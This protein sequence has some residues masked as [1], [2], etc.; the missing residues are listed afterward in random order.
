M[1][2]KTLRAGA[3]TRA[4]QYDM[5]VPQ[6]FETLPED[7]DYSEIFDP[8]FWRHHTAVKPGSLVRLRHALGNFDVIVNV[9]HKVAGGVLVEFFSGRPPRGIDPYKV[10]DDTR[11][12]ALK[13]R[14]APIAEDG[15]PVVR[16][17]YLAKTKFR[18][19][20]LGGAEVARD[21]STSAEAETVLLNYLNGLNMRNP[22]NDEL[23]EHAK[24]KQAA[25]AAAEKK[26]SAPAGA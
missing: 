23:L 16:T 15:K 14:V 5:T 7:V 10:Q 25:L 11:A 3:L 1:T 9:V 4:S 8:N 18:V 24:A 6:F 21:I 22:T 13:I 20:G 19:L 17:Q 2:E 12:E 26:A